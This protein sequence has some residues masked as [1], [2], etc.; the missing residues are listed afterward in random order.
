[1]SQKEII[2]DLYKRSKR[3]FERLNHPSLFEKE[4]KD[5]VILANLGNKVDKENNNI[6][7]LD[8]LDKAELLNYSIKPNGNLDN[9]KL[10][11]SISNT[12][13]ESSEDG[14][15]DQNGGFVTSEG[16]IRPAI[17]KYNVFVLKF[18]RINFINKGYMNE[19]FIMNNDLIYLESKIPKFEVSNLKKL[20]YETLKN[21]HLQ[22]SDEDDNNYLVNINQTYTQ[23]INLNE[24]NLV[25]FVTSKIFIF[26]HKK[27]KNYIK[28]KNTVSKKNISSAQST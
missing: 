4:S 10:K 21:Y 20:M 15:T 12:L 19:S 17:T 26:L 2:E 11:D 28:K 9:P 14:S 16:V 27:T 3:L 23:K 13:L 22:G 24:S 18:G 5:S 25:D 8:I 1:M 6:K 7:S